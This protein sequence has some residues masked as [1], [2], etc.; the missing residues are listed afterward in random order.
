[1]VSLISRADGARCAAGAA[2]VGA[3]SCGSFSPGLARDAL[4]RRRPGRA[5]RHAG[6]ATRAARP[7]RSAMHAG[8]PTPVERGAADREPGRRRRP[9][10]RPRSIAADVPDRGLRQ[11]RRPSATTVARGRHQRAAEQVGRDRPGRARRARRRRAGARASSPGRPTEART[12]TWSGSSCVDPGPLRGG[13]R[14][15]LDRAAL[16]RRHQH[17][18]PGQPGQTARGTSARDEATLAVSTPASSAAAAGTSA[19]QQPGR[20]RRRAARAPRRPPSRTS[21]AAGPTGR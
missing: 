2:V 10:P 8:M 7:P 1:M 18:G 14:H 13:E 15:R 19:P 9:P 21:G 4:A 17:A 16:D 11:R 20:R 3:R 6:L 12:T 5:L